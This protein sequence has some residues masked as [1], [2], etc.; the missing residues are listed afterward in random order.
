MWKVSILGS[1]AWALLACGSDGN[2]KTQGD[3]GTVAADTTSGDT[4]VAVP[5]GNAEETPLEGVCRSDA[6][7]TGAQEICDCEGRC[8]VPTGKSCTEDRNCGVPNWCNTCTGHCEPQVGVCE[9]CRDGRAC[10]DDGACLTYQ[11]GETYCGLSCV[12]DVGC[13]RG[14]GCLDL[15]GLGK[16][17]VARSG[18][19]GELGLCDSDRDC[20]AGTICGDATKTC[21]PGCVEDGQCQSGTVCVAGRCVP[22]CDDNADCTAPATC[23][24]GKCKVP[25]ACELPAD[26]PAPETYCDRVSGS[27]VPGCLVD[28]DCKDAAKRCDDG[29]CVDKGCEHNY[30]CAFGKVCES[31][32][33]VPFPANEPHCA[34]CEAD[35]ETNPSCPEPNTCVRFQSN[36][37]EPPLGDFCLVPCKNDP[38]DRCPSGWQ[39]QR[40]EDQSGGEQF[41]CARF[42]N[43]NPVP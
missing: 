38:I 19:C 20:P 37:N 5:D 8:V 3:G 27:C 41:Y 22:P 10:L 43:L 11:S 21:G 29:A 42:C 30:E 18:S 17:C 26:C 13:P 33:C 25:G 32:Q 16:Q 35:K 28:P 4:T 7:C 15:D 23:T 1:C 40:F 14:F 39:C 6:D 34:V 12:T 31:G 2:P 36:E 9:P 24:N